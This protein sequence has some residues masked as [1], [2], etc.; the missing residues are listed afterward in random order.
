MRDRKGCS[1]RQVHGS[2]SVSVSERA[3][4]PCSCGDIDGSSSRDRR[5][6]RADS[7]IFRDSVR[8]FLPQRTWRLSMRPDLHRSQLV[9]TPLARRCPNHRYCGRIAIRHPQVARRCA[10]ARFSARIA[11]RQPQPEDQAR[12]ARSSTLPDRPETV[13]RRCASEQFSGRIAIR[14]PQEKRLRESARNLVE[15]QWGAITLLAARL[16]EAENIEGYEARLVLLAASG[17][18]GELKNS[19]SISSRVGSSWDFGSRPT[20]PPSTVRPPREV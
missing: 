18:E 15:E 6:N 14:H 2:P 3:T 12:P 19:H 1:R 8:A 11:I 7:I 20:K 13:A 16:L 9:P 17:Q 4:A 10:S 5:G